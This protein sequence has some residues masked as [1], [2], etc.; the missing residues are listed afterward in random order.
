M[1]RARLA[2]LACFPALLMGCLNS[3]PPKPE[4]RLPGDY[5]YTKEYIRWFTQQQMKKHNVTGLSL[6]LIDDQR[7]VWVEG[8]GYA[9]KAQ[10][11]G[12]AGDPV[13]SRFNYQ[14]IHGHRYHATRRAWAH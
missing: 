1:A 2:W 7:V 9:D 10:C 14:V 11:A 6:A 13:S 5:A 8:F 12:D 3:A 4:I